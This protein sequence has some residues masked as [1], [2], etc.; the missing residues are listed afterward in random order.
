MN[1]CAKNK[2]E[3]QWE[4]VTSAFSL[5][6]NKYQT[7]YKYVK[8]L[9]STNTPCLIEDAILMLHKD[10]RMDFIFRLVDIEKLLGKPLE[11]IEFNLAFFKN[12]N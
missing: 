5:L 7:E 12:G 11:S 8:S 1:Y 10:K 9:K 2:N 6:N 3:E 4:I